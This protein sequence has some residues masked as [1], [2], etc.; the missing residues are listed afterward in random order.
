MNDKDVRKGMTQA[1]FN[2][3]SGTLLYVQI[4]IVSIGAGWLTGSWF[5]FLFALIGLIVAI[6]N[7]KTAMLCIVAFSIGWGVI[8]WGIGSFFFAS[9]G[10]SIVLSIIGFIAG[11]GSNYAGL[12][13][14]RD[15]ADIDDSD[16]T[17]K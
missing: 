17:T 2:E 9:T 16:S 12:E 7:R 3:E 6:L 5:V 8:G 10:A 11:L 15:I 14:A 4:A 1:K 13:H